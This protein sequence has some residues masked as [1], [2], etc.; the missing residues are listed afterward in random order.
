MAR[1]GVGFLLLAVE[2]TGR[3]YYPD[4]FIFNLLSVLIIPAG[5]YGMYSGLELLLDL[6]QKLADQKHFLKKFHD[7]A[8]LFVS[9]EDLVKNIETTSDYI[10]LGLF[11]AEPKNRK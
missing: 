7:A 5:W 4:F 9:E 6:P 8:Y 11:L 3:L 1:I 2:V 10:P